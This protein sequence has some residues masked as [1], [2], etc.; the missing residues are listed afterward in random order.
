M[1]GPAVPGRQLRAGDLLQ[2]TRAASVQFVE[3]MMFRLIRVLVD[4]PTFDWWLWLDGYQLNEKGDAI[5]RREIFVQP[6]GLRKLSAPAPTPT[7]APAPTPRRSGRQ[8]LR[9]SGP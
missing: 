9:R 6:A 1:T 2:V 4:R 3:P 5:A 8:P 7:P